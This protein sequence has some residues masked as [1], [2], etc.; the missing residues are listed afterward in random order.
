MLEA[1]V[2]EA[3]YGGTPGRVIVQ[4]GGGAVVCGP[5][6]HRGRNRGL[7]LTRVRTADGTEHSAAEFFTRGGYLTGQ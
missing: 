2:S 3:R 7:V 1:A 6:A 4:E 5:E